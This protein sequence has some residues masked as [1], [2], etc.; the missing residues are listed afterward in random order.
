MRYHNVLESLLPALLWAGLGTLTACDSQPQG[1]PS[2][3]TQPQ[4]SPSASKGGPSAATSADDHHR[5]SG[6]L[7]P[8]VVEYRTDADGNQV[9]HMGP[10]L[11]GE[12][13]SLAAVLGDLDAYRG[14]TLLLEGNITAACVKRRDWFAIVEGRGTGGPLRVMTEPAFRA[15]PESIGKRAR[16]TGKLETILVPLAKARHMAKEHDLPM[17]T[18]TEGDA[19]QTVLRAT[20]AEIF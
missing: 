1:S 17:P 13:V 9:A 19:K 10:A 5:E 15:P 12:K 16:V 18:E 7:P 20:A 2:P 4:A 6:P 14:K 3:Q 11:S 8:E